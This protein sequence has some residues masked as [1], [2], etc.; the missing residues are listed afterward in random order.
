[1]GIPW[2]KT[3]ALVQAIPPAYGQHVAGLMCMELCKLTGVP[4]ELVVSIEHERQVSEAAVRVEDVLGKCEEE[5][6]ALVME[7][8]RSAHGDCGV[9]FK[10]WVLGLKEVGEQHLQQLYA[11][12]NEMVG[13]GGKQIKVER[14]AREAQTN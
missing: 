4:E 11:D 13:R 8:V 14:P 9:Q 12:Y 7:R 10:Q 1:M 3:K 6:K 2:M 5:V